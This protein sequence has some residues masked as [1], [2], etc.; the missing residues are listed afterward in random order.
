MRVLLGKWL[1]IMAHSRWFGVRQIICITVVVCLWFC[2]L[3]GCQE[4][5]TE[6]SGGRDGLTSQSIPSQNVEPKRGKGSSNL[7]NY[8]G[9]GG[10]EQE[11][12]NTTTTTANT[13]TTTEE[14]GTTED[15]EDYDSTTTSEPIPT[16]STEDVFAAKEED[17]EKPSDS[18]V[19]KARKK[20]RRDWKKEQRSIRQNKARAEKR[21]AH[22]TR[23]DQTT[24]APSEDDEDRSTPSQYFVTPPSHHRGPQLDP[25]YIDAKPKGM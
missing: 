14:P 22:Q 4:I 7:P 15:M 16:T 5:T 8:V 11:E 9:L 13:T 19:L 17:E 25:K 20:F 23:D 12:A 10:P 2:N 24:V 1:W 6:D 21:T 18:P 3:G